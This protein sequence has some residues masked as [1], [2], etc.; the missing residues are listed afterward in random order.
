M[1]TRISI[2][3]TFG[4]DTLTFIAIGS[5]QVSVWATRVDGFDGDHDTTRHLGDFNLEVLR[6]RLAGLGAQPPLTQSRPGRR[7]PRAWWQR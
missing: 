7:K 2:E 1:N 6:H 4:E 3:D 5:S